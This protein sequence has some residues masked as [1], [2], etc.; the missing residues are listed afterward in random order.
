MSRWTGPEVDGIP[1]PSAVM[2][3]SVASDSPSK[4]ASD[5]SV[6]PPAEP[7]QSLV[8]KIMP[9]LVLSLLLGALFA[10]LV[11]RGGVPL[12]PPLEA[13]T[14][15][16]WGGVAGYVGV[17][18]I[19][20]FVRASRWRYLVAP[21]KRDV[22]FWEGILLNWIGFFA[23]FVMPL[24]LGELARP[25][26]SKMRQRIPISAGFGTVAVERVLDGLITSLCVLWALF[27]IP[28]RETEDDLAR[29]LPYYGY[30]AVTVFGGA[31]FGLV[32]FLWQKRLAIKLVELSFGL[33]SKRLAQVVAQ[34][35]AGVAEGVRSITEPRLALGFTFETIVYWTL[36]AL[37]MWLLAWSCGLDLTFSHAVAIMGILAIGILLPAGPGMFGNFQLAVSV[38]LKL[39]FAESV[40]GREGAVYIF[41]LYAIQA[42][43]ICLAGIGPLYALRLRFTDLLRAELSVE[44]GEPEA[45]QTAT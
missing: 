13:F 27:A 29:N 38:A 10:W 20:H 16:R 17:L 42:I 12:L 35:V 32:L 22:P 33:V 14:Q 24:R 19:T 37:G 26:L 23:I 34:K 30:L 7:T 5:Q 43:F 44:G 1:A 28:H 36:N 9:R 4:R 25:A 15:V 31:L 11:A 8:R 6:P 41:L 40:V 3:A 45:G 21:I 39:Y 2:S 18:L